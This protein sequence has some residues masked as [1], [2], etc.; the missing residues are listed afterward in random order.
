MRT[1]ITSPL[2]HSIQSTGFLKAMIASG[3][4]LR[5]LL[6]RTANVVRVTEVCINPAQ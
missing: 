5:S 2:S 1:W 3:V 4:S 6:L